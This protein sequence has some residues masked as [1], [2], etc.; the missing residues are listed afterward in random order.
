[1]GLEKD[2]WKIRFRIIDTDTSV[3]NVQRKMAEGMNKAN[4]ITNCSKI[5]KFYV[6]KTAIAVI[7]LYKKFFDA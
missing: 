2:Y 5:V 3:D 6:R 7:K 4:S 1:M